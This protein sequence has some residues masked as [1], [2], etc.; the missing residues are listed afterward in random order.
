[1]KPSAFS[2]GGGVFASATSH[3]AGVANNHL[4]TMTGSGVTGQ[5]AI[6]SINNLMSTAGN[7]VHGGSG[8][9]N[10]FGG[11]LSLKD[12]LSPN[13]NVIGMGSYHNHA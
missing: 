11:T 10:Q 1:M 12:I 8:V 13:F 5:G 2:S 9:S 6:N 4:K 3:S 7:G